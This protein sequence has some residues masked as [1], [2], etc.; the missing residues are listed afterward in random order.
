MKGQNIGAVAKIREINPECIHFHCII[1]QEAICSKIGIPS[2]KKFADDI[3]KLVNKCVSSGALRHRQF[4]E[5]L[6]EKDSEISDISRMQQVRWLSCEKVFRQFFSIRMDI[7]NFLQQE[8]P[9]YNA[10]ILTNPDWICNLAFMSD[11]TTHL[12]NLNRSLQ[13]KYFF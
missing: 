5:F 13:G 9:D 10:S 11:I 4:R 7:F 1:H 8:C 3:M 2:A 12:G 6:D